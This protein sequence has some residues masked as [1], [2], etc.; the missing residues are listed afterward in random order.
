MGKITAKGQNFFSV[1]YSDGNVAYMK[2]EGISNSIRLKCID[3]YYFFFVDALRWKRGN[4]SEFTR[5][6]T[7]FSPNM[8]LA[9]QWLSTILVRYEK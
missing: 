1:P 2:F 7:C 4:C 9:I 5:C 8:P 6:A 3:A